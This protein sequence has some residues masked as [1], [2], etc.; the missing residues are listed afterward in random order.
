MPTVSVI[1][2]TFNRLNQLQQ[3][4]DGL[5]RQDFPYSDFE[6]IVVSD[7]STDG[8]DGYLLKLDTPLNLTPLSQ[9]NSGPAAA[10][11]TGLAQAAGDIILFLDDDVVPMP[12]WLREHVDTHEKH[13]NNVVVLGPMLSPPDYQLAPWVEWEQAMLEKQY[14]DMEAGEWLPTARQFYTGN[15]SLRHCHLQAVGEFDTSFQRAEDVE[16]AYRL[17][18]RGLNFVFNSNAIGYHYADRSF[19][20]WLRTPYLYG[21]NDVIFTRD[22]GQSWLLP[23]IMKE[24]HTRHPIIRLVVK[25][26]LSLKLPSAV[27]I[28]LLRQLAK[29]GQRFDL[30][31]LQRIAYSGIYNLVNYQGITDELGSRRRFFQLVNEAA[32]V[33]IQTGSHLH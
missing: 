20:S 1:L 33:P 15:A 25:L 23:T 18:A 11:N 6:V 32:R 5:E 21:R 22:K 9:K 10:R 29:F 12:L 4:L 28:L 27:I 30:K 7:G 31:L 19:G 26:C 2:P 8:T 3:V 17:A 16:L 14:A 24:F 13:G